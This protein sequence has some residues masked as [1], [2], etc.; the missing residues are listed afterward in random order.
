MLINY[1]GGTI[2]FVYKNG[3]MYVDGVLI[4]MIPS[5]F[6]RYPASAGWKKFSYKE[7][8]FYF[9]ISAGGSFKLIMF[10]G[11]RRMPL[12]MKIQKYNTIQMKQIKG[13]GLIQGE[14]L[15]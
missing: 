2:R 4:E 11:M 12:T 3:Q 5:A 10:Q 13:N 15:D 8:V 14:V 9:K 1:A 7:K 6:A